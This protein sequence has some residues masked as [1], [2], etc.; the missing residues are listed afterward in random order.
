MKALQKSGL[1]LAMVLVLTA[2]CPAQPKIRILEKPDSYLNQPIE[3]VSRELDN[4][5]FLDE[6][7]VMA[8]RDWLKQLTLG[9]KNISGKNIMSF[10]IDIYIRKEASMPTG[11]SFPILFRTY[12]KPVIHNQ[13]RTPQGEVKLGVL[14]PGEVVKVRITD[15]HLSKFGDILKSYGVEDLTNAKLE[16]RGVYF[17]DKSRWSFG[18]EVRPAQTDPAKQTV[19]DKP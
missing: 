11:V 10:D 13:N 16:L 5:P 1:F 18:Q 2:V 12:T 8:D 9:I 17:E 14:Q 4:Q 19:P 7:R 3:V 15:D 6:T